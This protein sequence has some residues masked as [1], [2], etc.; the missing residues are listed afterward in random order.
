[1]F[2]TTSRYTNLANATLTVTDP[3]GNL[4]VLVYKRR[5]FIPSSSGMTTLVEHTFLQGERLDNIT[6]RYVGDP[7]QFWRICDANVV[8]Q[9]EELEVVGRTITIA[10]PGVG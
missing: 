9:P 6:A 4:R 10:V 5:R 2:D 7:L 3:D 8:L 1:M